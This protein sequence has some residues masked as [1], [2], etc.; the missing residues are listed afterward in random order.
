MMQEDLAGRGGAQVMLPV[1]CVDS[2][3][4]FIDRSDA[5]ATTPTSKTFGCQR[6]LVL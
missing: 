3:G 1:E 2:L 6:Q 4:V 5:A